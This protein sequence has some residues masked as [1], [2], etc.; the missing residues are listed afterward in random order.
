MAEHQ[1]RFASARRG[2]ILMLLAA[3]LALPRPAGAQNGSDIHE[4]RG[5]F[6]IQQ[7]PLGI[8][9]GVGMGLLLTDDNTSAKTTAALMMV[10]AS[11]FYFVPMAI[12]WDKPMSVAQAHL[13]VALG[14]RGIPAGFAL[15]DLLGVGRGQRYDSFYHAPVETMNLRPQFGVMVA[16]SLG[17]QIGGYFLARNL[18]LGRATLVT[19]YSDFGWADGLLAAAAV[20]TASDDEHEVRLSPYFLVGLVGGTTAG[21]FRQK[22][23][24]CT[25]GQVTFDRTAGIL[26]AAI[27]PALIWSVT[28]WGEEDKQPAWLATAAIL[29]NVAGVYFAEQAMK[30]APL[31]SGDGYIV[32][33]CTAGGALFGAGLGYLFSSENSAEGMRPVVGVATL[34]AVGG[35]Y[36]GGRLTHVWPRTTAYHWQSGRD[37]LARVH[38]NFGAAL[39]AASSYAQ[40]RSFSAPYLVEVEF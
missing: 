30:D 7:I 3:V 11:A 36:L 20:R 9:Y 1:Q 29:G 24:D 18:T 31:S 22:R 15:S 4:G 26:G 17:S 19:A 14:D 25:E 38:L 12:I 33:G 27:P 32:A 23:W 35:M 40:N 34:G 16:T 2:V 39:A 37:G 8:W 21:W 28:G 13:S 6:L 5:S 10:G